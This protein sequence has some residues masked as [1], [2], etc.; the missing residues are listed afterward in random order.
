MR[1]KVEI[2]RAIQY[3]INDLESISNLDDIDTFSDK[4]KEFIEAF[5]K[6]YEFGLNQLEFFINKLDEEGKDLDEY[7]IK[8]YVNLLLNGP[9]G[10]FARELSKG[11][12]YFVNTPDCMGL[13]GNKLR[14]IQNTTVLR[15]TENPLGCSVDLYNKL[16]LFMQ[17][18]LTESTKNVEDVFKSSL[19]SSTEIDNTLPLVDKRPQQRYN[20]EPTGQWVTRPN[21]NYMVK[22]SYFY[23]VLDNISNRIYEL[24]EEYLNSENNRLFIDNKTYNPFDD[25]NDS[26]SNHYKLNK[27]LTEGDITQEVEIDITGNVIESIDR[28]QSTLE[29]RNEYEVE[30]YDLSTREGLLGN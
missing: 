19:K 18:N 22:D 25:K 30:E 7:S 9:L 12:L 29:I 26:I 5:K 13:M 11:K 4:D 17:L 14:S 8:Y 6:I 28:R 27:T 1:T 2:L 10:N 23:I 16:P 20:E 3:T 15:N 24:V 21:G